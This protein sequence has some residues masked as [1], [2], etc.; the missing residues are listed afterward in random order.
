MNRPYIYIRPLSLGLSPHPG[1]HSALSR[2]PCA[3]WQVLISR[4]VY[5]Y[6][7]W[8]MYVDPNLS[9]LPTPSFP[10]VIHK[11]ILYICISLSAL[12]MRS[13]IPLPSYSRPTKPTN[14]SQKL[15]TS[16]IILFVLPQ[17]LFTLVLC[18]SSAFTEKFMSLL[19][20]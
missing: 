4:L 6:C 3:I 11:F 17:F 5:R 16:P 10:L 8:C 20:P 18:L 9:V 19:P 13:S 1:H 2:A 7:R 15:S 12:Q 14:T